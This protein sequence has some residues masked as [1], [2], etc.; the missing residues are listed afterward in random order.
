MPKNNKLVFLGENIVFPNKRVQWATTK[1]AYGLRRAPYT[2][3]MKIL[4]LYP[5]D[6]RRMRGDFILLYSLFESGQ[7]AQL[8]CSATTDHLRGHERKLFKSRAVSSIRL[9]FYSCRVVEP[10]NNL[11]REMLCAPSKVYFKRRLYSYLG[12]NN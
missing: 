1:L 10:W 4:N 12:I 3:R 7:V 8:F 9:N 2:N 11:P 6:V 5:L